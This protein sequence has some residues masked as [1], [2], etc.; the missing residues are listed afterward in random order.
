MSSRWRTGWVCVVISAAAALPAK[1]VD[2]TWNDGAGDSDWY[3]A[4]NWD[5]RGAP[6]SDDALTV[7]FGS[8]VSADDVQ[9]AD[10]GSIVLAGETTTAGRGDDYFDLGFTGTAL[11][12]VAS[13]LQLVQV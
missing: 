2:R 7:T 1:G 8:P 6:A 4:S 10:G 11:L 3:N 5:P 12:Q 9:I 13:G